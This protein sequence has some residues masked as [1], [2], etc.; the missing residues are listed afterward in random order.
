M[1]K[2]KKPTPAEAKVGSREKTSR[3]AVNCGWVSIPARLL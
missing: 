1:S 2:S 3:L